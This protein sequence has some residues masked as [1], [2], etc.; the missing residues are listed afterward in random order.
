[1]KNTLLF[2]FFSLFTIEK[3]FSQSKPS[4]HALQLQLE[5]GGPSIFSSLNLDTRL[6][7]KENGIG[8]R[9]GIGITPLGFLK[10]PCN[11][12]SLN[13]LPLAV[14]YLIGKSKNLLEVAGGGVLLFMSG[15]KVFCIDSTN[16]GKSFF[17]EGTTNY[18]FLTG[19]YRLQPVRKK[20]LTYRAFVSPLFQ[21]NFP[22]KFWA[23]R[24]LATDFRTGWYDSDG[25]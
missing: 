17:S 23:E 12:G 15:T 7:K 22:V 19:G 8:Y 20:G 25:L 21:K 24:V 4:S 10:H 5:F 18:W 9:I 11:S 13:A 14:N 1:M 3:S 6:S 2:L 16:M